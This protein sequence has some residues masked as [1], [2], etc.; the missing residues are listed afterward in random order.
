MKPTTANAARDGILCCHV[1]ELITCIGAVQKIPEHY[2]LPHWCHP[3]PDIVVPDIPH[4]DRLVGQKLNRKDMLL[5]CY[6]N[7][8]NSFAKLAVGLASS[9]KT[10]EIGE[11]HL[12]ATEKEMNDLKKVQ[13]DALKKKK[14]ENEKKLQEVQSM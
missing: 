9:K 3:P 11:R 12:I 1:L 2:I 13:A 14:N 6:G 8:C 4:Q 7:L 5:L 10:N